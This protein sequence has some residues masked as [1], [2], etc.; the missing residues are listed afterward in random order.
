MV[1]CWGRENT[2]PEKRDQGNLDAAMAGLGMAWLFLDG[3]IKLWSGAAA[4]S[5]V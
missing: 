1:R 2:G 5:A 4:T 3:S